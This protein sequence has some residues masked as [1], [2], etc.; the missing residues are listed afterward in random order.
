MAEALVRGALVAYNILIG[1][2]SAR[3]VDAENVAIS[4][5]ASSRL[6]GHF[7]PAFEPLA[8][9]TTRECLS[10]RPPFSGARMHVISPFSPSWLTGRGTLVHLPCAGDRCSR[11]A[12]CC[13]ILAVVAPSGRARRNNFIKASQGLIKVNVEHVASLRPTWPL[14]GAQNFRGGG[15]VIPRFDG[16]KYYPR[17]RDHP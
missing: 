11:M 8:F 1:V 9:L 12:R 15:P 4:S 10:L 16:D 13:G 14:T 3:K 2:R 5:R 7:I 6:F 17:P